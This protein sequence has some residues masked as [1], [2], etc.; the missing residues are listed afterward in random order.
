MMIGVVYLKPEESSP[1]GVQ[2]NG[3]DTYIEKECARY[4]PY[5]DHGIAC[6]DLLVEDPHPLCAL[7]PV[8]VLSDFAH[9]TTF[10]PL[11]LR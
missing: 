2:R 11:L 6:S 9:R 10:S 7:W 8:C 5:R 1:Y 4:I 3:R